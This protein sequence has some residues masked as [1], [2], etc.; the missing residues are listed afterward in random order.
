MNLTEL[1]A[2]VF[3][4]L[5][6]AFKGTVVFHRTTGGTFTPASEAVVG[7]TTTNWSAVAVQAP[8][9]G[10][11]S[12]GFAGDRSVRSNIVKL[13]VKAQGVVRPYAGDTVTLAGGETLTVTGVEVI[14]PD[15]VNPAIYVVQ[16]ERT[17]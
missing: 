1:G 7:S 4:A 3:N 11:E 9:R 16:A 12:E 2:A 14:V 10:A 8:A 17:S 15:G 6:T 5:P 13:T